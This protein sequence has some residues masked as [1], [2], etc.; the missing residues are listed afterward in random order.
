M[1]LWFGWYGFNP[2]SALAMFAPGH[3]GLVVLNTTLGAGAGMLS[4]MFLVW[5]RT[6]KWDLVFTLNGSLAGLVAITAGCAFVMP[7]SAIIIGLVGGILVYFAVGFVENLKIDDPVGAFSVHGV[8]GVW[9]TIAIGLFADKSIL[10][11]L[12]GTIPGAS[13]W[14]AGKGGLLVGGGFEMFITQFI[15]VMSVAGATV[16]MSFAMFYGLKAINRLRVDP[17]ADKISIDAYEHGTSV[18]PDVLPVPS[19]SVEKGKKMPAS[20]D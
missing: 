16:V 11:F 7:G 14:F 5:A 13:D 1:I 17:V 12:Y 2:G 18:W 15:G 3:I 10:T 9:G 19:V 6:G 20:G 8:C 4:C